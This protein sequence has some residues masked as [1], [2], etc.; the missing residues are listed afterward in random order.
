MWEIHC[1]SSILILH[2]QKIR[3]AVLQKTHPAGDAL[4]VE[5]EVEVEKVAEMAATWK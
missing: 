5:V 4:E 1:E 2:D 3:R